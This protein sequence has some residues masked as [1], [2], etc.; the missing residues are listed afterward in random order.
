VWC[1]DGNN[2]DGVDDGITISNGYFPW[3]RGSLGTEGTDWDVL[4]VFNNS[5]PILASPAVADIDDDGYQEVVIGSLDGWIYALNGSTGALKWKYDTKKP[6]YSSAALYNLDGDPYLEVVVGSNDTYIYC[7]DGKTGIKQW[8]YKTDGPIFS[9]PSIGDVDG[10]SKV[11]IVFGSLDGKIYCISRFG[12]PEWEYTTGAPIYSSPALAPDGLQYNSPWPMFRHD[13]A[14]TG[15]NP[16]LVGPG[17]QLYI[18]IGSDDG[19]LYKLNGNGT[20]HSRFLTNGPVHTSPSIA[21]IDGDGFLEILFYD[22]GDEPGWSNRDVFW[23]LEEPNIPQEAFIR[24]DN[25][26]YRDMCSRCTHPF[27]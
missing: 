7:L 12:F 23:C 26:P 9:S 25:A 27:L 15:V 5:E 16:S 3:E 21:D 14:R 20:L 22:W 13:C 17:D 24:V 1:F 4:W 8:R 18:F 11:E 2:S 6:V 19:Y 10:D